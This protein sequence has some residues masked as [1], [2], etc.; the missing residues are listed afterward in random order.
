MH[1]FTV[2]SLLQVHF[3]T[4]NTESQTKKGFLK[5]E[6]VKKVALTFSN[7][8]LDAFSFS[9]DHKKKPVKRPAFIW[10]VELILLVLV[11]F[12]LDKLSSTLHL[13]TVEP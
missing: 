8:H 4:K 13:L 12:S 6:F 5:Q 2:A 7:S 11:S 3:L 1:K 9:I 10:F